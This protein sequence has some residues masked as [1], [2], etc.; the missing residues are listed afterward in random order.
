MYWHN[1]IF[2]E[3]DHNRCLPKDD[4]VKFFSYPNIVLLVNH[5]FA[6]LVSCRM[7]KL[8]GNDNYY[9]AKAKASLDKV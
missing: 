1:V 4:N 8:A 2:L 7:S 6:M 9:Q 3:Q 5:A